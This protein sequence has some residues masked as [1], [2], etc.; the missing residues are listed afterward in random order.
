[1]IAAPKQKEREMMGLPSM[2]LPLLMIIQMTPAS[3]V[4][5]AGVVVVIGSDESEAR[6]KEEGVSSE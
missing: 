4:A 5:A 3:A 2:I 6:V 1:M